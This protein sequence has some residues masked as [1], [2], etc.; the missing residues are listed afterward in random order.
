MNYSYNGGSNLSESGKGWKDSNWYASSSG[1]WREYRKHRI[2]IVGLLIMS[3]FFGMA[4][5][6][7]Y[8]G[9]SD[10]N[11]LKTVAPTYL[12][13]SW[14]S[15][16]DGDAVV[17]GDLLT[18]SDMDVEPTTYINGTSGEFS[19]TYHQAVD[20]DDTS[21]TNLTW[22]HTAGTQLDF[23]GTDPD[24]ILPDYGDFVYFEQPFDWPYNGLPNG[25]NMSVSFGTTLTGDFAPGAQ[26]GNNLMFRLYVWILDSSDNWHRVYETRDATYSELIQD[27]RFPIT[28]TNL[29]DVFSG[30]VLVN[31]TQ[32]DPTNIVRVRVGMAPYQN[33]E[34]YSGQTPWQNYT[35]SVT[36][37]VTGV[38]MIGYGGYYGGL[39]TTFW[40]A[41]AY[42]Q[43]IYGSRVSLV[44]GVLATGLSTIVGVLVGLAAGYFGGGVDEV[45]MRVVDFLLVIPGLPLMMVLAIFLG[46]STTNIIIVI[47]ILGWT[48]TA[49]LIRSQVLAEKNKAYVESARAI[50][51]N[52]TYIMFRHILPNVTP[53]LFANIT[54]GV[55]GAILA[56]AG[57]SFL[58]LT[59][60]EEP[61]WG[62]MLADAQNGAAFIRG[63]WWVVLFPGLMIT[64]L[65]LSF[66]F[67]GHT[68][69]QVLNPRLRER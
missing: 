35:G 43:L 52:D 68:L 65:S 33:F 48:G 64:L 56:E 62:R 17:T 66:T 29:R 5:L 23:Y 31:G 13:P 60:I 8:L 47:S 58:G 46:E 20:S 9:T 63:A 19:T 16:F 36:F 28:Y 55:V 4:I 51:A 38:N 40:G 50:G 59:N 6:A 41:D 49:R 39:G 7:P 1:F 11:P 24:G 32:E 30:M 69:D 42:S 34:S 27:R 14:M 22:T 53:I 2:G 18:R 3:L 45:L 15:V 25:I 54:L 67:V 10:P 44:I 37:Q 12:A 21:Y 61:S 57:L 26:P